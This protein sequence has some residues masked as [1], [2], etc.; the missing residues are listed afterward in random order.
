M[1]SPFNT[2]VNSVVMIVQRST[3]VPFTV[4]AVWFRFSSGII[5]S[6]RFNGDYSNR[7]KR[8]SGASSFSTTSSSSSVLMC[9]TISEYWIRCYFITMA[10]GDGCQHELWMHP[11][12]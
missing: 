10:F 7:F 3:K 1:S 11:S 8:H 12:Q 6:L 5:V 9:S 2:I 4:L